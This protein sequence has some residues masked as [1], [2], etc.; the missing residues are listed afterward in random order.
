M[1]EVAVAATVSLMDAA[2]GETLS[3][4]VTTPDGKFAL[5]RFS[6]DFVPKGGVPYLLEAVK[7][8]G[9]NRP[10]KDAIRVRTLASFMNGDWTSLSGPGITISRSTTAVASLATLKGLSPSQQLELM[11]SIQI[12]TPDTSLAPA[13]PDT[14]TPRAGLTNLAFHTAYKAVVDSLAADRD[15]IVE[16]GKL[17]SRRVPLVLG[18]AMGV[19]RSNVLVRIPVDFRP[20][21][22]EGVAV[23]VDSPRVEVAASS[24]PLPTYFDDA[25]NGTM[26][27]GKGDL[28]LRLPVLQAGAELQLYLYFDT[29]GAYSGSKPTPLPPP[30]VVCRDGRFRQFWLPWDAASLIASDLQVRGAAV[31]NVPDTVAF[32]EWVIQQGVSDTTVVLAIDAIPDAMAATMDSN[33]L[34]RRYV[35]AGGRFV[36]LGD[37]HLYYRGYADWNVDVL[38]T[39]GANAILGFPG[40]WANGEPITLTNKAS[41]WGLRNVWTSNRPVLPQYLNGPNDVAFATQAATGGKVSGWLKNFDPAHPYSGFL[42]IWDSGF[43]PTSSQLDDLWNVSTYRHIPRI[44]WGNVEV[45]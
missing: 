28:R 4:T 9:N 33:A 26:G 27:D 17:S 36:W 43:F 35:D 18:D 3:S 34:V 30:L 5:S 16:A 20:W 7:G 23:D 40:D 19:T 24:T 44:V 32:M 45:L 13:T 38:G 6:R 25:A 42:R 2:T 12:G 31:R 37:F 21:L 11:G 39:A 29:A 8:L 22:S 1:N 15:P 14:F 10:G 41:E